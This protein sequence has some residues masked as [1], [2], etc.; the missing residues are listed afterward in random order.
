MN[1]GVYRRV[2]KRLLNRVHKWNV[3]NGNFYPTHIYAKNNIKWN[4]VKEVSLEGIEAMRKAYRNVSTN[5][6]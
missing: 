4:G 1:K 5:K 2:V 3:L 6:K